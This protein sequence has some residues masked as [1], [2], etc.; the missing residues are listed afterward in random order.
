MQRQANRSG[1]SSATPRLSI[2][3]PEQ[4]IGMDTIT[5]ATGSSMALVLLNGNTGWVSR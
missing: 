1:T 2:D 4:I 3:L 5:F